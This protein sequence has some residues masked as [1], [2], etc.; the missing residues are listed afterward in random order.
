MNFSQSLILVLIAVIGSTS[1]DAQGRRS[2][3]TRSYLKSPHSHNTKQVRK[4]LRPLADQHRA[5]VVGVFCDGKRVAFGV[6]VDP[7][8]GIVTKASELEDDIEVQFQGR[9]KRIQA[10]LVG[11]DEINDLALLKVEADKLVPL[12]FRVKNATRVGSILVTITQDLLP[13]GYGVMSVALHPRRSR[14]MLGVQI[15]KVLDGI[16]L[17]RITPGSAAAD[18]GLESGDVVV[19]IAGK[20]I[21]GDSEFR[22]AI[23]LHGTRKEMKMRVLRD[24]KEIDAVA[25]LKQSSDRHG[26][27]SSQERSRLWGPMSKVRLG[28]DE[29]IQ[30]DTVLTP[31]Q[32]GSPIVDLDGQVIGLNI[33]RVG[34]YETLALT[35]KVVVAGIEK[36]RSKAK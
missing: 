11:T 24:G 35:A 19:S 21:E 16:R 8:G 1:L 10:R 22:A 5:S 27:I 34:R 31:D 33:S 30:H 13:P 20:Q 12:K 18:A 15:R 29:V 26:P 28:F 25:R 2:S 7:Q 14:P 23:V 4:V 3:R 36:I 6:V 9:D 17:D 32:C